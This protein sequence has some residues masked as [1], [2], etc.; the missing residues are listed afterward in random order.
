MDY[1]TARPKLHGAFVGVATLPADRSSDESAIGLLRAGRSRGTARRDASQRATGGAWPC[2]SA[3]RSAGSLAALGP[4]RLALDLPA[5]L[6][7]VRA[8]YAR[9][10]LLT[11]Q[12]PAFSG[13]FAPG[14]RSPTGR[15][16]GRGSLGRGSFG[17]GVV[18]PRV[19]RLGRISDGHVR[20]PPVGLR[21]ARDQRGVGD[22]RARALL[23]P[24]SGRSDHDAAGLGEGQPLPVRRPGRGV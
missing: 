7:R 18:G 13:T 11:R 4:A 19:V 2:R 20:G 8:P 9:P 3:G 17:L 21:A 14:R 1:T 24:R 22:R 15:S 23:P 16:F 10:A 6:D 12:P 5:A